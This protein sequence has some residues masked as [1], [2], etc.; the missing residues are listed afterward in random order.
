M[1]KN[2]YKSA[3]GFDKNP[4]N[5]NRT[6]LNRKT[7]GSVILELQKNGAEPVRAK[8]IIDLF[9]SLLNCSEYELKAIE[10]DTKQPILNRIVAKNMLNKNG[11]EIV[12]KML[13]RIH[14]KPTQKTENTNKS[15]TDIN[16]SP[17]EWINSNEDK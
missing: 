12:E 1:N 11:F 15:E 8:Q 17:V 4:Q 13:D 9:E 6:G 16:I 10:N 14:G 2:I 7:V 5:I 3:K